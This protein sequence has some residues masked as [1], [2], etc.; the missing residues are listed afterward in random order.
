MVSA[1]QMVVYVLKGHDRGTG[2]PGR[3]GALWAGPG[4]VVVPQI[5][6]NKPGFSPCHISS[7]LGC[8]FDLFRAS[9]EAFRQIPTQAFSNAIALYQDRFGLACT[10]TPFG[11]AFPGVECDRALHATTFVA[12]SRYL[13]HSRHMTLWYSDS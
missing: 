1:T 9:H 7:R 12:F 11:C 13:G 6:A 8:L 5:A 10:C 3:R 2:V 4:R